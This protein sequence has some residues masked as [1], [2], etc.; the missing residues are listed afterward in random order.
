MSTP[1][2]WLACAIVFVILYFVFLLIDNI[3]LG[4]NGLA[5]K[6]WKQPDLEFDPP[7][8]EYCNGR[9]AECPTYEKLKQQ[10][11]RK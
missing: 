10:L 7:E 8:C 4:G 9:C 6:F 2:F 1:V 11:R 3:F 5:R